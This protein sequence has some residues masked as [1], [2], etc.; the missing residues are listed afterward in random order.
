MTETCA[1]NLPYHNEQGGFHAVGRG[2]QS[3]LV[4]AVTRKR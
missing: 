2:E 3:L 4:A 1:S